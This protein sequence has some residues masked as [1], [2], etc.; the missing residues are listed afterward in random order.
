M[1]IRYTFWA[2]VMA[3][4]PVLP[5]SRA[6]VTNTQLLEFATHHLHHSV[7]KRVSANSNSPSTSSAARHRQVPTRIVGGQLRLTCRQ[8]T[9]RLASP[10]RN[11][12]SASLHMILKVRRVISEGSHQVFELGAGATYCKSRRLPL[13]KDPNLEV[14]F[15]F[16]CLSNSL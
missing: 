11:S 6:N 12:K 4:H 10:C 16:Q 15:Q 14:T 9:H 3:L 2:L 8:N 7:P 1:C 13:S 5:G